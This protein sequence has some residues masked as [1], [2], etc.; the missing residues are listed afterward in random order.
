VRVLADVEMTWIAGGWDSFGDDGTI[1]DPPFDNDD[2]SYWDFP[3]PTD[4]N[5]FGGNP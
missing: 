5:D 2:D 3:D 1:V 4:I